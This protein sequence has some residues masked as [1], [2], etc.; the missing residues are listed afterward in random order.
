MPTYTDDIVMKPGRTV[1]GTTLVE[2]LSAPAYLRKKNV[3]VL[4]TEN[5]GLVLEQVA[6]VYYPK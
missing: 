2:K 4:G 5:L 3:V 6:H 1:R